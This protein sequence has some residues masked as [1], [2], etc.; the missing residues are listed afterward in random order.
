MNTIRKLNLDIAVYLNPKIL[1]DPERY[2]IGTSNVDLK[3]LKRYYALISSVIDVL[4]RV[5]R[6]EIYFEEFYANSEKIPN[7]EALE[8]HV[9]SYLEDSTILKNKLEVLLNDLKQD[10]GKIAS[11]GNELK[12][13]IRDLISQINDA[14]K[15]V[16]DVRDPHHHRGEKFK[17]GAIAS[18]RWVRDILS[19]DHPL[20]DSLKPQFVEHLRKKGIESFTKAKKHWV[21]QAKKNNAETERAIETI[22][23]AVAPY[24]YVLLEIEPISKRLE[25]E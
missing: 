20:R 9:F 25:K 18:A 11:N 16:K 12:E 14:F 5:L 4:D 1:N 8:Y 3:I 10:L 7:D 23:S 19:D 2:G 13:A 24:I 17:D 21:A 6:Y 15:T 22:F